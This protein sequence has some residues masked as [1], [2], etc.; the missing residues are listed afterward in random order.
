[1]TIQW[2][3]ARRVGRAGYT[4]LFFILD[5]AW[6]SCPCHVELTPPSVP[7]DIGEVY[8]YWGSRVRKEFLSLRL[9][10][11]KPHKADIVSSREKYESRMEKLLW[12]ESLLKNV[13]ENSMEF[14]QRVEASKI[15]LSYDL[16]GSSS[17][18]RP[19]R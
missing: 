7:P 19:E 11:P 2:P 8:V 18:Q 3:P 10:P 17:S 16:R 14:S 5:D 9:R 15:E 4:N 1:L 12:I 13:K 6:Y